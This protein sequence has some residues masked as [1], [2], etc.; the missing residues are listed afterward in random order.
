MRHWK[1][2]IADDRGSASLEFVTAGLLMLLPLVYL[3]ITLS[4]IQSGA[5]AVEGAAREGVRVFVESPSVSVGTAAATE[6]IDVALADYGI[7]AKDATVVVR[8]VPK[9][10]ECLTREGH[11]T[12]SVS[13]AVALPLAPAS[14]LLRVPLVIPLQAAST[15]QVSRFHG[16]TIDESK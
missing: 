16:S 11:V 9:P 6:A 8:C 1:P 12:V 7:A 2:S 13:T 4:L 3:V 10:D 14:L 15:E 5:F